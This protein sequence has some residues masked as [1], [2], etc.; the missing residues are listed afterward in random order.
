MASS[1]HSHSRTFKILRVQLLQELPDPR[2]LLENAGLRDKLPEARRRQIIVPSDIFERR[3]QLVDAMEL[4]S[5]HEVFQSFL[6]A[7]RP[8]NSTLAARIERTQRQEEA[9]TLGAANG[10]SE[11]EDASTK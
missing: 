9:G 4:A 2:L 5:S 8:L 7:L 3:E 11:R 6:V 10:P 1:V